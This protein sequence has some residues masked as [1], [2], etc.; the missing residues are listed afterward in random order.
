MD[1]DAPVSDLYQ[2]NGVWL[3]QRPSS[4]TAFLAYYSLVEHPYTVVRGQNLSNPPDR[5]IAGGLY[6]GDTGKYVTNYDATYRWETVDGVTDWYPIETT[7]SSSTAKFWCI[8]KNNSYSQRQ[9]II[10]MNLNKSSMLRF[11]PYGE[12]VTVQDILYQPYYYN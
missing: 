4:G 5:M 8:Y 11:F 2:N 6:D 3:V 9:S 12:S 10:F 1:G 7:L